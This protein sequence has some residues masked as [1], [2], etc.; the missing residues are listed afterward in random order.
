MEGE[1][2]KHTEAQ[3][4]QT[5]FPPVKFCIISEIQTQWQL[6]NLVFEHHI[7]LGYG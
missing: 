5:S 1:L 7:K 6:K 3:H 2:D 4:Y